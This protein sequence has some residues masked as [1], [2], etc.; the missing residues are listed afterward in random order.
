[1]ESGARAARPRASSRSSAPS[2]VPKPPSSFSRPTP[3]QKLANDKHRKQWRTT[4]ELAG[5]PLGSLP[6]Q[7]IDSALVLKTLLPIWSKTP[8]TGSRLRGRLEPVFAWSLAHKLYA[9]TNPASLDVLRDALPAKPRAKHH[10]ALPYAELPPFM[11]RLR[12]SSW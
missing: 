12:D 5:A 4:L 2:P 9:G 10:A 3:I 11:Q 8:E 7:E 1:M 6:L